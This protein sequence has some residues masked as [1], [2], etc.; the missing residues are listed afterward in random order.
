MLFSERGE[1]AHQLGRRGVAKT[2]VGPPQQADLEIPDLV[3]L[4]PLRG[5]IRYL[6]DFGV[7]ENAVLGQQ[8]GTDEELVAD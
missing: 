2:D 5:Q 8:I 4:D 7:G 1:L 3:K 6:G